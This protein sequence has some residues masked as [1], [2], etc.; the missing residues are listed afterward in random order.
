MVYFEEWA[1]AAAAIHREKRLKK[2]KRVWK[3]N[4]IRTDNPDWNDLAAHWYPKAMTA[5][6]IDN[7]LAKIAAAADQ[8]KLGHPD[9]LP[10]A[11]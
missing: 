4:L 9:A 8:E 10:R 3:I 6:E 11:G 7:W 5:A 2:W 1:T